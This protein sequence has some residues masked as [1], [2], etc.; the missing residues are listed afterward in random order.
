[1]RINKYIAHSGYTSRRKAD[2]LIIAGK[3]KI[4]GQVI[5]EPGIKVN[6]GDRIEVEGKVLEIEK[7]F[8]IKLY[9]P[10]GF[11]TSN[12]DP[13]NE[14]DLNDLIDID[15]RFFAAGRLDKDSEGL[16][17]IT[18]D[19][20]FTNNLIHPKFKLDKEYIVKIDKK[21]K[22]VQEKRFEKGLDIGNDEKTSDA[23]LEYLGD[24]TY[25]VIIHQGYNR[26]IRRMFKVFNAK[27]INL[28]R[29]RIGKI[30]L[31]NLKEKEYRYFN[32]EELKFVEEIRR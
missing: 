9:K 7:K 32:E 11:I 10:V 23:K 2:D 30:K 21:L 6:D 25:R 3:V 18:N 13:Y 29:I 24:N 14:K 17:I 20:D 22:E 27:V 28:K 8:Y 19:G 5:N 16:L 1:M 15:E 12:F 31:S 4:N 26:Q